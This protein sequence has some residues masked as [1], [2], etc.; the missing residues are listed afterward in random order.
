MDIKD[1]DKKND[2]RN[3]DEKLELA[4]NQF[5]KY[6]HDIIDKIISEERSV[7]GYEL[8]NICRYMFYTLSDFR[9]DIIDYLNKYR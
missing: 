2:L 5:S 3:L 1:L 7:N 4:L 8:D 6:A 9:K